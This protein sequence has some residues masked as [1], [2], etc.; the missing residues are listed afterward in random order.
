MPVPW[1]EFPPSSD[2]F[3]FEASRYKGVRLLHKN[4]D[5]WLRCVTVVPAF[6]PDRQRPEP[7]AVSPFC[8]QTL[9]K[10]ATQSHISISTVSAWPMEQFRGS[11]VTKDLIFSTCCDEQQQ[12]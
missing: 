7:K 11:S 2:E 1:I 6:V 5:L 3:L 8:H 4:T 12:R 10:L 9:N